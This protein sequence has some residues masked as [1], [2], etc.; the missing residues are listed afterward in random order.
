MTVIVLMTDGEHVEHTFIN[1]NFK[2]ALS[3]MA[4]A[5]RVG[6]QLPD[7][8]Y[9]RAVPSS[10]GSNEYDLPHPTLALDPLQHQ[11][12]VAARRSR[13]GTRSGNASA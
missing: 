4:D 8:S 7:P 1:N 6:R 12:A 9:R 2:T 13:T 5:T 10:A 11:A 3:P